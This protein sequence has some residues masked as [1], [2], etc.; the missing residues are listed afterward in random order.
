MLRLPLSVSLARLF[1]SSPNLLAL[2][3]IVGLGFQASDLVAQPLNAGAATTNISPLKLPAIRNGGFLQAMA[4]RVDDPLHAR[5]LVLKSGPETVALCVVDSCMLPTDVCDAIKALVTQQIALPADR[6]LIS[7]THT[8][9]APG[10]MEM[11]LGTRKDEAYTAQMIPQV[12]AAIVKAHAALAPAKAGWAQVDAHTFTHCRRWIRRPDKMLTDPFGQPSVRAMMHPGYESPDVTGPSGPTDPQLS[13]LSLVHADSGKP[14]ALFAN[15]SMHYFGASGGF[16]ADYFGEM[17]RLLEKDLGPGAVGIVSQGTSGD[18]HYMDYSRAKDP[19]LTR[20]KYAA[21]LAQLALAARQSI[22]HRADL[23]LAMAQTKLTLSRRLPSPERLAWAAP[24]NAARNG[25]VPKSKEEVYAEQAEWIHANPQTE[26]ILQAL[27]LG[28]LAIT[29][30]PNEVYGITGLKLKLQSPLP[31]TFNIELANG[32]E[33]YIPPP[34][35]HRLGGYTTWPARTAGLEE[36]DEPQIVEATLTLLE[37]VSAKPRRPLTDADSPYRRAILQDKPLAYWPLNDL[38]GPQPREATGET[39]ATWEN[40]VALGLPGVQRSG[41]AI[42]AE[43]EK[44][45]PFTSGDINRAAHLAG[46]RLRATLPKL[47]RT[48]TAEIWF[49]NGLPTDARPVTAY[50]FSRGLDGD[51][52]ALGE[53]LGIGGTHPDVPSGRLF[54]YTGNNVGQVIPGKTRLAYRDWHHVVLVRENEKL[55]VYLDGQKEIEAEVP[56]TLPDTDHEVFLGGRC[57]GLFTLEGKLDEPALYPTALTA[58]QV[59]AHFTAAERT[60]PKPQPASAPLSPADSLKALRLPPGYEAQIVAAEPLVLDPVAFDWD[61]QARLWVVEM[62]DYPLGLGDS[63]ASGGRV[64]ILE[65]RDAD[66]TYDHSALFAEG[67]NFPNGLITWRDGVIVTA[68]PDILFLRDTN[69]DGKADQKEILYTGLTEGNQQL[70]ANGLRWGLDNWIYVAAGGHHGKHGADTKLKSSRTGKETLVGSRDFRIRPDTGEIEPQS[71]PTQF[72]RNRDDWGHWFGTQNSHPLWHYVLPEHYL[73]RNPHLATGDG[74]VQLP[75]GSNPPVYPASPPEKRYHSF[76]QSGRYTSACGGMIYQDALLFPATQT[77]AFICEPFHNLVQ[78][79]VLTDDGVTFKATRL[80]AE[81][82]PD[83]F[84]STDRWCRPVMTRTGPDG[85]LWVA[86]MYRYM[87]EHPQWLPKEGKDEL[88]PHYRLGEDKGRIYRIIKKDTPPRPIPN[89]SQLTPEALVEQ[90]SSPNAWLRDKTQQMLLWQGGASFQLARASKMLALL[91]SSPQPQTRLQALCTLEGLNALTPAHLLFALKDPHP[92]VRENALRLA[93]STPDPAVITAACALVT[94]PD[95]KVRLQLAFSLGQWPTEP[96]SQALAQLLATQP[97]DPF[98]TTAIFS[99]AL[100]HLKSLA[101]TATPATRHQL[102]PF[103]IKASNREVLATLIAPAIAT[104]STLDDT[105]RWQ[106]WAAFLRTLEKDTPASLIA[107]APS[108]RLSQLLRDSDRLITTA[109]SQL[110]AS[111]TDPQKQTLAATVLG[112]HTPTRPLALDFF[113]QSLRTQLSSESWNALLNAFAE[114][115][116]DQPA[117]ATTTLALWPSLT[118]TQRNHA[119]DTLTTRPVWTRALLTAIESKAIRPAEIDPTRRLALL[120]HSDKK[121]HQHAAKVFDTASSPTRASIVEKHLPA[122]KLTADAQRGH[123]VYQRACAACHQ[124]GTEGLAI[125]PHL[126]SVAAHEPEK[127]LANILDPNLD[128]QPGYHAYLATL[129][130]GQQ[131]FGL[132]AGEAGASLTFKLPDATTRTLR[133]DEITDLKSTGLS[134]MPEGLEA[135]LTPQDL[136]DLIHFLRQK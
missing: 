90:L 38:T 111:G 54:F 48:Y 102:L 118:P 125:G 87:I 132:L 44:A 134:L 82:E 26:L 124:H 35:Q 52:R 88:L 31:A 85:A 110:E 47:S 70:R 29:A 25:A 126:S 3:L 45:N 95:P 68:A 43:P 84:A 55:T 105:A 14:I 37:K 122:L 116:A 21:G 36:S 117:V 71:G 61:A 24:I 51:K 6:I 98:L 76:Q 53:H 57:D 121:I 15:Y 5:A 49:W 120:S 7:S 131:L 39:T 96:A 16:S 75:G 50:L 69:G 108:D 104:D 18:L 73:R 67:L 91:C 4:D 12:A 41:G 2:L 103:A 93:E 28:D 59:Q 33:G 83:F 112:L 46:G 119:L 1:A 72:G 62:A 114:I 86:D 81:N 101:A 78:A 127:I 106:L 64:R 107:A 130:N 60:A 80:G 129:K 58:A 30:L 19:S 113:A 89:L 22:Q 109:R 9:S 17:A 128:I 27:R 20:Q 74:R 8:H 11:C 94:D 92:R 13:L 123:A 133:R 97:A 34:E 40:G 79:L 135:T 115:A 23:P 100:P 66:G 56:W 63:G 99:S 136:A 10:T 65:D 42:S 32:A 77:T